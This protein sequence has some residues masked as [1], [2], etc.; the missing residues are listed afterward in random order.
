MKEYIVIYEWTGQNYSA[1][2]PDLPGCVAAG[3]TLQETEQ[4]MKGAI[5]LYI[6]SIKEMKQPVPEP[7]TQARPIMVAA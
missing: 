7:I 1:Y 5:E 4:L 2:A 6:E 3:D